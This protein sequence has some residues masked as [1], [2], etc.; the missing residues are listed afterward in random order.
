MHSMSTYTLFIVC[1]LFTYSIHY[2]RIRVILPVSLNT[3]IEESNI[4]LYIDIF[5]IIILIYILYK[6]RTR[7]TS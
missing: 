5:I 4:S 3:L 6:V 2:T 1:C 7:M